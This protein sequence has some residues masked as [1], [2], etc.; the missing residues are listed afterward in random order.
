[1]KQLFIM[2]NWKANKTFQETMAFVDELGQLMHKMVKND[3]EKINVLE[4]NFYSIAAP[5]T[6]LS[7]LM[8]M[9]Y[10]NMQK[11]KEFYNLEI[12]SQ[13]VSE[14]D[15]G[16]FTG[17]SPAFMLAALKTKYVIIG[18]SERR[19]FHRENEIIVNSK[20]KKVLEQNMTPVICVG[21]SLEEY[22]ENRTKEVI[23]EQ[24]KTSLKDL[25]YSKIIISYEPI[26]AIG[27]KA[28]T[29]KEA[30]EICQIIRQYTNNQCKVLYGGSVNQ[31]N[32]HEL[33]SQPNIDG[34]LVGGA[35]LKAE[36]FLDLITTQI[37]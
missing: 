5:L 21:E 37:D 23:E 18:H 20:A 8:I 16:P 29:P 24:L 12:A 22:N 30:N 11:R 13:D 27:N 7:A 15:Q 6:N 34:F 32:I 19:R 25:D 35:S 3:P 28:A 4:H 36:S 26:W 2:A 1:M 33:G 31:S 14:F 10:K 9:L 17:D